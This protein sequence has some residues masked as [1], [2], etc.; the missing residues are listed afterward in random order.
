MEVSQWLLEYSKPALGFFTKWAGEFIAVTV[1]A[2]IA[3]LLGRMKAFYTKFRDRRRSL[4][5]ARTAI[6]DPQGLWIFDQ[7]LA[8]NIM[9]PNRR[10]LV[11]ANAKGGVGKTTVAANLAASLSTQ[12]TKPVLLIDL[13]FQG[14]LSSMAIVLAA[15]RVV[16]G[17]PSRASQLVA[18]KLNAGD[19]LQM[20]AATNIPDIRVVPAYYDL[21]R[22]ENRIMLNWLIGDTATDPRY[23]LARLIASPDVEQHFGLVII[24]CAPR[25]TTGTIQ[26]LAAGSHLLIPTILDGPSGEAVASFVEQVETFRAAGLCPEIQYVGVLPTMLLPRA[27]YA[28]ERKALGDRLKEV[29]CA[30]GISRPQ[31]LDVSFMASTDVRKAYGRGIAYSRLGGTAA[32]KKVKQAIDSLASIVISTIGLPHRGTAPMT[33]L[34]TTNEVQRIRQSPRELRPQLPAAE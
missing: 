3:L 12:L 32:G 14:S 24:D 4:E 28:A 21:A 27:N 17:Q 16:P 7:P 22:E 1:L 19:L 5:R 34:R 9:H 13:D 26:A 8:P 30:D 6:N 15:N 29:K 31:L 2:F 20:P 23:T 10:V 11:I 25:L 33:P 18:N